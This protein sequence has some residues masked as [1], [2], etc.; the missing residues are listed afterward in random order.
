MQ[1]AQHD[2]LDLIVLVMRSDEVLRATTFLEIAEPRVACATCF[3]FRCLR[4]E[5]QLDALEWQAVVLRERSNCLADR[6]SGRRDSVIHVR[7]RKIQPELTGDTVH[8]VEQR[9]RVG[10]T[11][12]GEQRLSRLREEAMASNVREHA[13]GQRLSSGHVS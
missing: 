5:M 7:N 1:R 6:P 12:D 10:A 11:R 9:D 4:A 2:R 3:G 13:R 8:Q